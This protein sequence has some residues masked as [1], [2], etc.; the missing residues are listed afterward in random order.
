MNMK[1]QFETNDLKAII[2]YLYIDIAHRKE[3]QVIEIKKF[4]LCLPA[5]LREAIRK[6]AEKK[7]VSSNSL[8]ITILWN[9]F[10][11]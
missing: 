11:N 5:E 4:L 9:Y 3:N 8:I 1:N 2:A 7:G 6:E 10:H